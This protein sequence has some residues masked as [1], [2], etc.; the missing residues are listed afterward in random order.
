MWQFCG[1]FVKPATLARNSRSGK[2]YLTPPLH[3]LISPLPW[4]ATIETPAARGRAFPEPQDVKPSDAG[5]S[6][7][8]LVL[9]EL[10]DLS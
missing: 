1:S 3:A 8:V 2:R 4:R 10:L 6:P 7:T 5:L 9:R